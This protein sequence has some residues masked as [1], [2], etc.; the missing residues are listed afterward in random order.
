MTHK[1]WGG[2]RQKSMMDYFYIF[3][4]I[5]FTIYGQLVLKWQM[6]QAGPLPLVLSDRIW[7][8]ARLLLNPWIISAF[9]SAF[10]ASL[11]WMAA[12]S[13]FQISHAYPFTSLSF[14]IILLLSALLF[15][16][17]VT[18]LKLIGLALI[19]IGIIVGSQG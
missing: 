6:S 4:T 5:A 17:P 2:F 8:L 16:E 19:V 18:P 1:K 15:H 10:L 11:C 3:S 14:V 7:F 9:A 12:M 13:R